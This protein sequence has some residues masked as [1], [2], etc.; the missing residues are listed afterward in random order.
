MVLRVQR[1]HIEY[2]GDYVELPAGETLVGRDVTCALRFNDPA[3]SRR[4][5]RFVR[6]QNE[7][8]V[9]DLKSSNGTLLNGR[10]VVT[11]LRLTDGDEVRV[12]ARLLKVRI[13]EEGESTP[14]PSTLVLRGMNPGGADVKFDGRAATQLPTSS[15]HQRC[16]KCGARVSE[17]DE[18]CGQCGFHW[19]S[20]RPMSRTDVRPNP[21]KAEPA[22][23]QS[24][25]N[26]R[27]H[28]RLPVELHLVYASNELEIEAVSRDLSESGVFVC[29]QVLD[30]VGTE[31]EL[32]ILV[33][34]GPPVVVKGVVRRVVERELG[35][36]A[37]GLGVEFVK[38]GH[39]ELAW[40][41]RTIANAHEEEDEPVGRYTQPIDVSDLPDASDE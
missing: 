19:G 24:G 30:P 7:V 14:V 34:G 1:V 16:P 5:M 2:M 20:F 27:R 12:G 8:F 25:L 10:A 9:E 35:D 40:I 36:E 18:T 15:G 32:T 23:A 39:Q 41:R 3:V 26:R 11:P 4:H 38:L 28:D 21:L 13:T 22:P 31:C 17:F 29:S 6:R 37:I 33:D